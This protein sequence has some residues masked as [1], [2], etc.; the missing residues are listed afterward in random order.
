M[1]LYLYEPTTPEQVEQMHEVIGSDPLGVRITNALLREGINSADRLLA[2]TEDDL[3]GIRNLGPKA[4]IRLGGVLAKLA[5]EREGAAEETIKLPAL[6]LAP[7][8]IVSGQHRLHAMVEAM[9]DLP[10][11][12]TECPEGNS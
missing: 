11:I 12:T 3:L 6:R 1:T 5:V 2:L 8:G 4:Y 9:R 7:E 10:Y